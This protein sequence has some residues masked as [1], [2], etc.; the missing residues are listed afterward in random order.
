MTPSIFP[1]LLAI[2]AIS[3]AQDGVNHAE[4]QDATPS[5]SQCILSTATN[6]QN[7]TVQG[8]ARSTSHDLVFDIPACDETV[9]LTFAGESDNDV[10][11]TELHR[12]SELKRFQK[13]TGSVYK[14]SLPHLCMSC[15]K[16][17]DVKAELTGKLE[18][19]SMPTNSVKDRA[20]FIRDQSGKIIGTFGWGHPA[21]F[22]K[23]RLVVTSVAYAKARKLPPPQ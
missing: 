8:E 14:S 15:P 21:S 3:L 10:N 22:A 13:Y 9:L 16:Y 20:G 12:D 6:G 7:V 1:I 19:A 4:N 17:G 23:Y 2:L 11:I 5:K 18:I